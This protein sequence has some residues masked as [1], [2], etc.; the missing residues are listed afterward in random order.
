LADTIK[1]FLLSLDVEE[2][3]IPREYGLSIT[4][5]EEIAV[6]SH[7]LTA[8]LDL[9]ERMNI[10]VTCFVTVRFARECRDLTARM[11]SRHEIASHGVNHSNLQEGD[12]LRARIELGELT[13]KKIK[14]FRSPK[15]AAVSH[16]EILLA[17]YSYNS[18]EN[19]IWLPGRYMNLL[20]PRLPYRSGGLLNL[21]ISA[22]P[23]IRYPL[24]WLSFKHT[25]LWLFKA[26]SAWALNTDG[27]LNIYFHPWE[28]SD[29]TVWDLPPWL[30]NPSGGRMIRKLEAYLLW[31][32]GEAC[33][34]TCS[35]FA[36][37]R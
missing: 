18:S 34:I 11:A 2:F 25:P 26:M 22:S 30:K 37:S 17:G 14:G 1:R 36:E 15:L 31:L 29:L 10:A 4:P 7:G 9:L 13:G 3:D 8:A 35:E 24:F 12:L 20:K 6:A 33:F 27:Y 23:I 28:L 19:P 32:K 21:P 16:S 5:A